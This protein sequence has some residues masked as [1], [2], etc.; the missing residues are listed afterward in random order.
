MGMELQIF[1]LFAL[2]VYGVMTVGVAISYLP[3]FAVECKGARRRRLEREARQY[4]RVAQL[5][6]EFN[7]D[8]PPGV[9]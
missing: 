4:A 9:S 2:A 6:R 8:R 7:Q 1:L 5:L 3:Q